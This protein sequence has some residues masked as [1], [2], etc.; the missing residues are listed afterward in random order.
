MLRFF[1]AWLVVFVLVPLVSQNSWTQAMS[2]QPKVVLDLE[3]P[4]PAINSFSRARFG[5]ACRSSKDK[6][7]QYRALDKPASIIGL[8]GAPVEVVTIRRYGH[9]WKSPEDVRNYVVKLLKARTGTI[10]QY[11]PWAEIVYSDIVATVQFSD[12]TGGI[13]EE[14]G[15]HVCFSDHSHSTSWVRVRIDK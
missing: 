3:K 10:Y 1:G 7:G 15:G 14:S 11:E 12:K 5:M 4:G 2:P 6:G 8:M 9:G 13:L